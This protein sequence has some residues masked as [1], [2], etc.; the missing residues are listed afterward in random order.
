MSRTSRLQRLRR[1]L[2]SHLRTKLVM[3]LLAGLC[4]F[5]VRTDR[6]LE[7]EFVFPLVVDLSELPGSVLLNNPP[8]QVQVRMRGKGRN[9]LSFALFKKGRYVL[10]PDAE[11]GAHGVSAKNLEAEGAE[12]LAVQSIF[13]SVIQIQLDELDTK[14]LPVRFRGTVSPADD[15]LLTGGPTLLPDRVVVAG[16]RSILDTLAWVATEWTDLGNR[17]RDVDERLELRKPW[18]TLSLGRPSVM[19][20]ARIERRGERRFSGIPLDV[21][22]LP[23]SLVVK[24]GSFALTVIGGDRMLETL[25]PGQI[26]AILDLEQIDDSTR[27]LPCRVIVPTG[28]SWKDPS[29]ARFTLSARGAW[30][31]DS[32]AADSLSGAAIPAWL[33]LP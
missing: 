3:L 20:S 24:P 7:V 10:R 30:P 33:G 9:L 4:W 32:L 25:V 29:P 19:L 17:K 6:E 18:P 31:A 23:D 12:D 22:G 16:A 28:F 27:S 15:Y 26:Q 5:F 1:E 11:G 2:T 21:L 14:Q 8:K 13:P